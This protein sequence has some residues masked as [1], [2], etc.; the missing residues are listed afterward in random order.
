[1]IVKIIKCSGDGYWYHDKIGQVFDCVLQY[2]P[3]MNESK[4]V[5]KDNPWHK[6]FCIDQADVEILRT[7]KRIIKLKSRYQILKEQNCLINRF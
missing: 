2:V 6:V 3:T 5:V 1:M 7:K 4:F